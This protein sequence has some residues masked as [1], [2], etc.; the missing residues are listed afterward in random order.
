MSN[1]TSSWDASL[2][3][4]RR[5][6]F[7]RLANI[8]VFSRGNSSN[9]QHL[10]RSDHT[11]LEWCLFFGDGSKPT[12]Y[13]LWEVPVAIYCSLDVWSKMDGNQHPVASYFR[14]CQGPLTPPYSDRTRTVMVMS[15]RRNLRPGQCK[16]ARLRWH[17]KETLR[18]GMGKIW[19]MIYS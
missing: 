6:F 5:W 12:Y 17:E 11:S 7:Q 10:S 14:R 9:S 4:M 15:P 13:H 16:A 8:H 2:G 3:T 19:L 18:Q 1:S